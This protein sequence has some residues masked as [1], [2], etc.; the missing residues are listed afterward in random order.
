VSDLPFLR[1]PL[2]LDI[3][4]DSISHANIVSNIVPAY[5]KILSNDVH[6]SLILPAHNSYVSRFYAFEPTRPYRTVAISGHFCW[7]LLK[8]TVDNANNNQFANKGDKLT[9][10]VPTNQTG[11]G[12]CPK[13]HFVMSFLYKVNSNQ[14][15]VIFSIGVN[16]CT[17]HFIEVLTSDIKEILFYGFSHQNEY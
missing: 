16:D 6:E 17:P 3:I 11:T 4:S 12:W 13:I 2:G 8:P 5:R 10:I 7:P 14:S 1:L 9:Y 15:S